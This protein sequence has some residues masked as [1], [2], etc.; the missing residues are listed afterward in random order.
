MISR[1]KSVIGVAK[2]S[3]LELNSSVA[4]IAFINITI[5]IISIFISCKFSDYLTDLYTWQEAGEKMRD[6]DILI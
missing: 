2:Q 1:D 4:N 5:V 6:N 3:F